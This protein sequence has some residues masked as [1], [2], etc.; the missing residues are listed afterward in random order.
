MRPFLLFLFSLFSL[1][2]TAKDINFNTLGTIQGL[3]QASAISIWQD[4]VGR[5]W[6][7]N[8][9][10][11]QFDGT[12][13]KVYR[14]SEY[15]SEIE[16]S[17]IHAICGDNSSNLFF[18][19]ENQ[20]VQFDL[21]RERFTL[22]G[23]QSNA[24]YC[25]GD[26]LFY[27][28]DNKLY[29][30]DSKATVN[31][32]IA[33]L[34]NP[35]HII[36]SIQS[37]GNGIFWLGTT[38]G[39]YKVSI[40]NP[41]QPIRMFENESISCLYLDSN[42]CLWIGS[43]SKQIHRI[44]SNGEVKHVLLK[45][46]D[47][48]SYI[49]SD[50]YCFQEDSNG[51]IWVGTLSGLYL[52]EIKGD[53]GEVVQVEKPLLPESTIFSLYSDKQGTLWIGSYYGEVR[54]FN[55]KTNYYSFLPSND[56][57]SANLHGAVI[58]SMTEDLN[59]SLYIATEGSGLNVIHKNSA[60]VEHF[61]KG[62]NGLTHN[63]IRSVWFDKENNRLYLGV[64]MD[65]L[66]Y[67]DL[68]SQKFHT[69]KS[70]ILSSIHEK[71]V[72]E[73]ISYKNYLILLTQDGI[74]KMDKESQLITP[75][76]DEVK[77]QNECKGIIR[78]IH[79]D[80]RGIL[81]VSSMTKGLF[82]VDLKNKKILRN[83]GSGLGQGSVIPS[84]VRAICGNQKDG[85]FFATLK[86]GL[87]EYD[88]DKD[89]FK[90]YTKENHMLLSDVCY[91]MEFTKNGKLI[92][93]SDKGISLLDVRK[94]SSK[95]IRLTDFLPLKALSGD[96][97]L[98][99]S[100]TSGKIYVGGI[101]G[102]MSFMEDDL[103][104]EQNDYNLY[105]SSLSVNNKMIDPNAE[106]ILN[107][108]FAYTTKIK[109]AYNQNT[110]NVTFASSNYSSSYNCRYEYKMDGLDEF[111][112][113][114]DYQTITYTSLPP[115][116]Y[117][118]RVRELANPSKMISLEIIVSAPFWASIPA[119][120]VYAFLLFSLLF[121]Y[122][123]FNKGKA[124][125]QASLEMEQRENVRIE[126]LNQKKLEFFTN[127]SHEFRTPLM[128]ISGQADRLLQQD[129]SSGNKNKIEKIQK[130]S[131]RMQDLITELLD[132]RKLEQDRFD[133]KVD[134]HDIAAFLNEIFTS[135]TE[136]AKEKQIRYLFEHANEEVILW[137]DQIQMQKV[138]YNLLSS[139][140][141][142]S[143]TP[144]EIR[145]ILEQKKGFAEVKVFIKESMLED[146]VLEGIFDSFYQSDT[147]ASDPNLPG[148]G[149]GLALGKGIVELHKG[150][151]SIYKDDNGTV[152]SVK[153]LSGDKHFTADQLDGDQQ[154]DIAGSLSYG[155]VASYVPDDIS[156]NSESRR[157]R[158][159]L[160]EDDDDLRQLLKETFSPVYDVL[161]AKNGAEGLELA[162]DEKPDIIISDVKMP[163]LSGIEMCSR[164][165]SHIDTF[166]IPIVLLTTQTSIEQHIEGVKCGADDYIIKPFNIELL[167][168]KCNNLVK[169]RKDLSQKYSEHQEFDK[170]ELATNSNDQLF[171]EHS[172]KIIQDNFENVSFDV[173]EWCKEMGIG[174]TSLFHKVKAITGMTPNDYILHLK[175]S[176]GMI[177]LR[178]ENSTIAEVAYS[179][180][181][182][183]P[184]YFSR[185]FKNQFGIT[186]QQY[187]K[188]R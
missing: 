144:G 32:L 17:N 162:K 159:L 185:C 91:N 43:K 14:L 179:L 45:M 12:N 188:K 137:F 42:S 176:K 131:L 85:L 84:A 59:G 151:L 119:Y 164:L 53:K 21:V 136:Y 177:L 138:F 166:H 111:W 22:P 155:Q 37:A 161:E 55:T 18:L 40:K 66:S 106:G 86:S 117:I 95:H 56:R 78:V 3:S 61:K 172:E 112:T 156:V 173:S 92:L 74:F 181:F 145:L 49:D 62:T 171:L 26:S 68:K 168:L 121:W 154:Q 98:F 77:L 141:K 148:S 19:A 67:L 143:V 33:S 178:E 72:E 150:T 16:D 105:F 79:V 63:K 24:L 29:Y 11:N 51:N 101:Y 139:A 44:L 93:T 1:F 23:I 60:L 102:M 135:F 132:F 133:L 180:G 114:T 122:V 70:P 187:R 65:G 13:V 50:I 10:L 109:L 35:E 82:T 52:L 46:T 129:L 69:I 54:F 184:A 127:I 75:L 97:G 158:M 89:T 71:I 5:M 96:C 153:L 15:F 152:L 57:V 39:L 123:R 64:Y 165:K 103:N 160:V 47:D 130:Q 100:P 58:G 41:E 116:N 186:P 125:L 146:N 170:V 113:S 147:F 9:A 128:L 169:S 120:F 115:G 48:F 87:L 149:I 182:S 8:D 108:G 124:L 7:G 80:N 118:L 110:I 36:K 25:T 142:F 4:G 90:S 31:R 27:A 73:I 20:L 163:R 104:D 175:M 157:Y 99:V 167:F 183:S 30:Y 88:F 76:F 34:P 83:Y 134:S 94:H 2:A 6:F 81:W 126:E 107:K 140:F 174:R 28:N 38:G